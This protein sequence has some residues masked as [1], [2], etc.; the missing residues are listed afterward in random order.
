[1]TAKYKIDYLYVGPYEQNAYPNFL[2]YSVRPLGLIRY[3][4]K[5]RFIS[6]ES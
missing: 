4:T 1:M 3:M 2:E 6:F 5:I